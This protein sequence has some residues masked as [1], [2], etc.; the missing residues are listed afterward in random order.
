MG[1][2]GLGS[3]NPR[4]GRFSKK[5]ESS[6]W[7]LSTSESFFLKKKEKEKCTH[8]PMLILLNEMD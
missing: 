8:A 3:P 1:L 7:A 4:T 5:K 2:R 6:N